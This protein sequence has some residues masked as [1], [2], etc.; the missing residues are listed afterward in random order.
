MF[1]LFFA[2]LLLLLAARLVNGQEPAGTKLQII[3]LEIK[4]PAPDDNYFPDFKFITQIEF[5]ISLRNK[6]IVDAQPGKLAS[7]TDSDGK[8]LLKAVSDPLPATIEWWQGFGRPTISEDGKYC[9]MPVRGGRIPSLGANS[10]QVKGQMQ[11]ISG[12]DEKTIEVKNVVLDGDFNIRVGP[13]IMKRD[14]TDAPGVAFGW[15]EA[16]AI[17]G[18]AF[19]TTNGKV[20]KAAAPG[21]GPTPPPPRTFT[22]EGYKE[23]H[24]RLPDTRDRCTVRVTYFDRLETVTVPI[25]IQVGVGF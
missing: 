10:I 11:V 9:T 18:V 14:V 16:K 3:S 8:N 12:F 25:D 21:T 23:K 4:K 22:S 15:K 20:I 17:K 19:L 5:V 6:H 24:Y 1:R 2:L 13:F 7:L